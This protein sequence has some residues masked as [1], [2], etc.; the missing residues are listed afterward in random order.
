MTIIYIAGPITGM[1]AGNKPAFDAM[2]K[3]LATK[4]HAVMNPQSLPPGMSEEAY[5]DICLAMVRHAE[6]VALLKGWQQ[7]DGA[8]AELAYA[9]K[10]GIPVMDM[11]DDT[12][13]ITKCAAN[14]AEPQ[15]G[16]A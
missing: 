14:D 13:H 5:M 6:A 12:D 11:T 3:Y 2:A 8:Q 4:G 9:R 10:R 7:S 1:P 16:A 15:R